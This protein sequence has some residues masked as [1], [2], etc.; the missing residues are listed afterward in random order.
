M[1]PFAF[2]YDTSQRKMFLFWPV[3]GPDNIAILIETGSLLYKD[4][5]L[6]N[7][8][9]TLSN[10]RKKK[11][12]LFVMW[13]SKN[14]A[15]DL[16][17]SNAFLIKWPSGSHKQNAKHSLCTA[18]RKAKRNWIYWYWQNSSPIFV[19][20]MEEH[21]VYFWLTYFLK[22]LSL[23]STCLWN[24][25]VWLKPKHQHSSASATFF[26]QSLLTLK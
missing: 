1:V 8:L 16:A 21:F 19:L 7:C 10:S 15:H 12:G 9:R 22:L 4:L 3:L 14:P 18:T 11:K 20:R 23:Y 5:F 13:I 17:T 26:S 25:S 2:S 6:S 24:L